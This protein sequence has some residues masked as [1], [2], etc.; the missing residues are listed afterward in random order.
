ME[1]GEVSNNRSADNGGVFWLSMGTLSITGGTFENNSTAGK[2]GVA[3][4]KEASASVSLKGGVFRNNRAKGD[5]GVLYTPNGLSISGGS[6]EG[7]TSG[8]NGGAVW[9]NGTLSISGG[10]FR[11]N[12]AQKGAAIYQEGGK[13]VTITGFEEMQELYIKTLGTITV[14]NELKGKRLPLQTESA[15]TD[16]MTVA[17]L[18]VARPQEYGAVTTLNGSTVLPVK[19]GTKGWFLKVDQAAQVCT[20]TYHTD[21]G[22]IQDQSNYESYR[23]GVGLTLPI[24]TKEGFVFAGWYMT[25]DFS[26]EAETAIGTDAVGDKTYYAKWKKDEPLVNA[27]KPAAITLADASYIVGDNATA[28]DG[29]TTAADG[30]KITYR[31]YEAISKDNQD[32]AP[33]SGETGS[34]FT[35]DTTAAGTRFYYVVATNTNANATGEKTAETRSN[36]AT[37][38]VTEKAVTYTVSYDW[39]TEFPEGVT[40]PTD[41]GAYHSVQDAEAAMDKTYTASSTS[42]AQKDGKYGTWTFSGWTASVE[43]TVVKFTG[44]WTFTETLKV[45][46]AKPAPITLTDASYTVGDSAAALNGETTVTDNGTITYQWYEATSKDD[47]NG[48]LLEGKTDPIF[49]PDT[50]AAGTRF[51]YVV[52]TNTNA[53][54]TGEKT[55]EIRSNTVTLTVTEKAVTYTVSYDWG[56]EVPDGETLPTD[57]GAYQSVQDAEAA[58]DKTY[59]AS[60]TSTAQ[61]DGKD[62]TWI[63]SGWTA[64]VEGTVVKF[65]GEWTFTETS[66]RPGRPSSSESSDRDHDYSVSAP[67]HITGGALSTTPSAA[68]KGSTVTITAKPDNGYRLDKLTVIDQS[69]NRLSLSDQGNGKYT[70]IMPAG[71]VSVE[72]VFA[73]IKAQPEF[74]DVE[75]DSY[76]HDAVHWALEKGIT[77]GTSTDT[78][79]PGASC[80]RAQM[81]TFLW[82]AAGSPGP[83]SAA[84]PFKDINESDYYYSAILWAIENGITSGTGAGTFSPTATVTRGQTVTF[85]HRA[86]GSPLAGSSGFNDVSDGAYYAKAVAWAAENGIT[87][88]TG[89]NKFAPNA[90]CTRSQIVTLLYRANKGN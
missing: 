89:S 33:I 84:N 82:R 11:D 13:E 17:T 79:S 72:P 40:L 76:Y 6:Y 29:T 10:S 45:D 80:T 63:F 52:V 73:P 4:Q 31:W 26:G 46:A 30:G 70:F 77:E 54:A 34:T 42:T 57:S 62:G 19:E 78:F 32:G 71:K 27:A 87:S 22:S 16:G 69:G 86:A 14:Q 90:D 60:S 75:K 5:G 49:T 7:N 64:S 74:K 23:V 38:T 47:Q 2:G 55:A 8:G 21:G 88:G 56:T 51:F 48:T 59:T 20:V 53:N 25:A 61:K 3:Y 66:V 12:T 15:V 36:T 43:G 41:S 44:K 28:L 83:K 85:L 18:M 9:T 24:P 50:T 65:T 58:M 37:I 1:G 68:V 35:P 67:G 39:G 81:V